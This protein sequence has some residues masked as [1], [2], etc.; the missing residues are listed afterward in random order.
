MGQLVLLQVEIDNREKQGKQAPEKELFGFNPE[1]RK[2][3]NQ[4]GFKGNLHF[5][6]LAGSPVEVKEKDK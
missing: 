3:R 1:G 5:N 6:N 2:N 4:I